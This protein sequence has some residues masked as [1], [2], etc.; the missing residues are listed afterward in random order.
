MPFEKKKTEEKT[1]RQ[2]VRVFSKEALYRRKSFNFAVPISARTGKYITGQEDIVKW[3]QVTRS[4]GDIEFEVVELNQKDLDRLQMGDMPYLINPGS[5]YPL[6]NGRKFDLSY[7]ELENGLK[8][9]YTNPK[10]Y[11]EYTLFSKME[12]VALNQSEYKKGKHYFYFENK[13]IEA[14]K[15]ITKQDMVIDAY[16]FVRENRSISKLRDLALL[17]NYML[18]KETIAVES[19]SISMLQNKIYS[20]CEQ[21]PDKVLECKDVSNSNF[22]KERLF[23]LKALKLKKITSRDGSYF[24]NS[25]YIGNTFESVIEFIRNP[26]NSAKV[27]QIGAAVKEYDLENEK[28]I[29]AKV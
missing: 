17:L 13:E 15:R 10:D 28:S 20:M 29:S 16:N 26:E 5:F 9:V 22:N 21:Y 19:V 24:H 3:N 14:E 23:A 6:T 25:L 27:A 8:K 7:I 11:A 12:E 1:V 4:N 2:E 18:P